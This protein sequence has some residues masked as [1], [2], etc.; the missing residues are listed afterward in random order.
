MDKTPSVQLKGITAH[1]E[2]LVLRVYYSHN[3]YVIIMARKWDIR[4]TC[5]QKVKYT[6]K[7]GFYTTNCSASVAWT[8]HQRSLYE[9]HSIG[10]VPET[11]P[12]QE[13]GVRCLSHHFSWHFL[14]KFWEGIPSLYFFSRA[15]VTNCHCLGHCWWLQTTYIYSFSILETESWNL[16]VGRAALPPEA[17]WENPFCA[18]SNVWPPLVFLDLWVH[19]SNLCFLGHIPSFSICVCLCLLLFCLCVSYKDTCHWI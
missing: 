3:H 13:A 12:F 6:I 15:T 19:H 11:S 5:Y 18:S 17:L 2:K 14:S 10:S 1:G 7:D 8:P 9:L 16:G 4:I